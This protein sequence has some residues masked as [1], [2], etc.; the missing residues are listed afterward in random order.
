MEKETLEERVI[1]L[2]NLVLLLGKE[3]YA[4]NFMP[5]DFYGLPCWD[6]VYYEEEK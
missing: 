3:H 1:R 6:S 5:V 4:E 2:E